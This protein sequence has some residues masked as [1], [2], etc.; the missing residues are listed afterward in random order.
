MNM[1]SAQPQ[2]LSKYC[3]MD[4]VATKPSEAEVATELVAAIGAGDRHAE[5]A[6]CQRY[7]RGLM[8]LLRRLTRGDIQLAEDIHQDTLRIVIERLRDKGIDDPQRLPGY[9]H[10]TA[11]N[12]LIGWQ[13][14]QIRRNTHSDSEWIDTVAGSPDVQMESVRNEQLGV[15]LRELLNELPTDRD[16][17]ILT[18]FYLHQEEK[19]SICQALELSDLHF[20][21]VLYRAKQRF[22]ELL[23]DSVLADQDEYSSE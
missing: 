5:N 17:A 6:L 4:D 1:P 7:S 8:F 11:K 23:S 18:R 19:A 12:V 13:R 22:K 20:D 16:R 9:I 21:R 14:K 15:L 10:S 3:Q 2:H